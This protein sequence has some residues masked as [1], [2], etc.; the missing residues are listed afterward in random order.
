MISEKLSKEYNNNNNNNEKKKKKKKKK[1]KMLR[2]KH[3]LSPEEQY[4][5]NNQ[6]GRHQTMMGYMNSG[7]INS[8]LSVTN[9]LS[10]RVKEAKISKWMIKEET[11]LILLIYVV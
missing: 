8:R 1:K 7:F 10:K 4:S 5:R 11:I 3:I 6:I 9:C 2:L